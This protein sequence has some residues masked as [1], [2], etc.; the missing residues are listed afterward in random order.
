MKLNAAETMTATMNTPGNNCYE[1]KKKKNE[2]KETA[3]HIKSYFP[4]CNLIVNY[5]CDMFSLSKLNS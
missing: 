2:I 4:P 1:K 5:L 3:M